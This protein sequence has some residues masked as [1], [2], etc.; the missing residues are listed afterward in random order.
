[1]KK[2]MYFV[3]GLPRSGSTMIQCILRQNPQVHAEPVS[4]LAVC[5]NSIYSN[6]DN[7]EANKEFSNEKAK[8][9]VLRGIL[10]NYH[11]GTDKP[12]I[13]DKDRMWISR[14]ALL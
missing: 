3:A 13:F 6:W 7:V 9:N 14:I 2:K 12:I 1:M 10:Q 8:S 4:S 11:E 5:F